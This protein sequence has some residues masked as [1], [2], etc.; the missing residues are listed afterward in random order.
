M[1]IRF[2]ISEPGRGEDLE[3]NLIALSYR[4]F[5]LEPMAKVAEEVMIRQNEEGA[6]MGIDQYGNT[7]DALAKSTWKTR[8][9]SGPPLAP[10]GVASRVVSD[11]TTDLEHGFDEI[12]VR[13]RWPNCPWMRFHKTGAPKNNMPERDPIGIRPHGWQQLAVEFHN[14]IQKVL[15]GEGSAAVGGHSALTPMAGNGPGIERP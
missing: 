14:W 4:I 15:S 11:F 7:Y 8:P 10:Q 5:D 2:S 3:H 12:T 13:G 9:G 6:L 1:P